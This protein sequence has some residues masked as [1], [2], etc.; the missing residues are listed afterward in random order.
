M[1]VKIKNN[2]CHAGVIH[3][4][5]T[6]VDLPRKDAEKLLDGEHAVPHDESAGQQRQQQTPPA[7]S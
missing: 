2:V 5:G 4:A 7:E 6:V 1:K 3:K